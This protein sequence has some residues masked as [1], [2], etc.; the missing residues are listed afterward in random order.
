M[1]ARRLL[2]MQTGSFLVR[3]SSRHPFSLL[4]EYPEDNKKMQAPPLL[5]RMHPQGFVQEVNQDSH[6]AATQEQATPRPRS[7]IG[8][9][10]QP[11]KIEIFPTMFEM[12]ES[13]RHLWGVPFLAL[14]LSHFMDVDGD[15]A[16]RFL[17]GQ[18]EGT[19]L[20]RAS[21][22]NSCLAVSF[23]RHAAVI[24]SVIAAH[25]QGG[26]QLAGASSKVYPAVSVLVEE[27]QSSGI[28]TNPFKPVIA[29]KQNEFNNED[30]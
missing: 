28:F 20:L 29:I 16:E 14:P 15:T 7:I 17:K 6:S 3:C 21:S 26:F 30:Y 24:K 13:K 1:T 27:M 10:H 25:Q 22:M 5:I 9:R 18:S 8:A 12:V 23:I 19:F 11:S 4:V 2:A